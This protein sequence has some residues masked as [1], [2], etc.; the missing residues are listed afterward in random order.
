MQFNIQQFL[1]PINKSLPK[2]QVI[3]WFTLSL[4]FACIYSFM[5]GQKVF[6]E[7]YLIQDDA[8]HHV[9]WMQR[10]TDSEIFPNDLIADY[11]QSVAPWGYTNFY[12][13]FAF[14]GLDPL[15]F[16]KFLPIILLLITT[17]YCFGVCL[18]ILPIPLTGFIGSLVLNQSL[19]MKDDIS[20]GTGRAFIYPL[21][22]AFLYYYQQKKLIPCLIVVILQA[23]FYPQCVLLYGGVFFLDL[24]LGFKNNKKLDQFALI[25]WLLS[26]LVLIPYVIATTPF[27]PVIAVEDARLLPE[28]SPQGR[29]AF[30]RDDNP[31]YFFLFAGRSGMFSSLNLIPINNYLALLLPLFYYLSRQLPLVK[32]INFQLLNKFIIVSVGWFILAHLFLFK[33]YLPSRYTVHSFRII[34]AI[35]SAVVFTI[36]LHKLL[37]LK[38]FFSIITI[39]LIAIPVIFYPHLL[40]TFPKG[41]YVVGNEPKLY[42]FIQQ[43]PKDIMIASLSPETDNLPS[44]TGRSILVSREY[45]IPFHRGYYDQFRQ[46]IMDTIQAQYTID[47]DILNNYN[48]QYNI[49]FWLLEKESF[50]SEY[51][52]TNKWFQQFQPVTHLAEEILKN[53]QKPALEIIKKKCTIFSTE[54]YYIVDAQCGK[55][56]ANNDS[57]SQIE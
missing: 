33:L 29:S 22:L 10:F 4:T 3:F 54:S 52:V 43:Q 47:L 32:Q 56:G 13:F 1:I 20:S 34:I 14:L 27:A 2:K 42:Q 46:R 36:I 57:L 45:A 50:T 21:F 19:L 39:I 48:E 15:F 7:Q 40:K 38:P 12:K 23:L 49:T 51:L 25:G 53:D 37:Q 44:F 28:F 5:L 41:L 18:Q 24:L 55:Q 16:N 11:F 6:S 17:I 9:F 35:A 30:F 26:V 8:R 31:L